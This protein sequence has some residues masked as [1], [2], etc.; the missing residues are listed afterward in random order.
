MVSAQSKLKIIDLGAWEIR[1]ESGVS[2]GAV[3]LN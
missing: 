2:H 1:M 3:I